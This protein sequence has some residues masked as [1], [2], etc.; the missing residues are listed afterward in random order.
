MSKGSADSGYVHAGTM[1]TSEVSSA[2]Y[3]DLDVSF[4]TNSDSRAHGL[5]SRIYLSDNR[6]ID[7]SNYNRIKENLSS[8]QTTTEYYLSLSSIAHSTGGTF[9]QEPQVSPYP[10]VRRTVSTD[11]PK[12]RQSGKRPYIIGLIILLLL[13]LISIVAALI[14]IFLSEKE[15]PTVSPTALEATSVSFVTDKPTVVSTDQSTTPTNIKDTT[16]PVESL[17]VPT[18]FN[19]TGF[20]RDCKEIQA[21]GSTSDGVYTIYPYLPNT[22]A[23]T[24]YCDMTTDGG[25]WTTFQHRRDGSVDFYLLWDSYRN[26]FGDAQGEYW[27]GNEH[28]HQLTSRGA[29]DF[30]VRLQKFT[31]GWTYAKYNEISVA[32]EAGKYRLKVKFNS[33]QGNAGDCFQSHLTVNTPGYVFSTPDEDN[34]LASGNCAL[35]HRG[36]WWYNQCSLANL[37]GYYKNSNCEQDRDCNFWYYLANNYGGVKT[38]YMMVRRV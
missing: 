26:G 11:A 8:S 32:D 21:N 18:I 36:A 38:S 35:A 5:Y 6:S 14:S 12:P 28:L 7:S 2:H 25:G 17:G 37:N 19:D 30:Y 31:G 10:P 4:S 15:T 22:T 3:L 33:Y 1:S 13:I 24:V 20:H 29:S 34:D 23:V 16:S 27:L 9:Q